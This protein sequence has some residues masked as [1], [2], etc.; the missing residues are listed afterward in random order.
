VTP[1]TTLPVIAQIAA[2][3]AGFTALVSIVDQ[4]QG[5]RWARISL[6]RVMTMLRMSLL[7]LIMC[8]IPSV[9]SGLGF[10]DLLAWKIALALNLSL[11]TATLARSSRDIRSLARERSGQLNQSVRWVNMAVG[12][13]MIALQIAALTG[14]ISLPLSGVYLLAML[15]NLF[16]TSLIFFALIQQLDL[17][18]LEEKEVSVKDGA[19]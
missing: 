2:T 10:E 12:F 16:M 14:L 4:S 13:A 19:D 9:L 5:G 18:R 3:F 11:G 7:I 8:L 1:E 6:W 17:Q 15:S